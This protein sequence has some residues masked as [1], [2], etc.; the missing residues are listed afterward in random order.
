MAFWKN[1]KSIVEDFISLFYPELCLV[2]N[3]NLLKK[4]KNIFVF[5]AFIKHQKPF[6]CTYENSSKNIFAFSTK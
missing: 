2:C 4:Q 3:E 6:I 5:L 1:T